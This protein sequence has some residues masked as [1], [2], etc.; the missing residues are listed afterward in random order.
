MA[1]GHENIEPFKFKKG[2][3]GNPNGRPRKFITTL[4]AH[5]YKASEVGDT[6]KVLLSL[7]LS[8]LKDLHKNQDDHTIM[9]ITCAKALMECYK[10]GSLESL[11]TML[12][13]AFGRPKQEMELDID[14]Q[15]PL[16]PD[17]E[18]AKPTKNAE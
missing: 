1:K 6:I 8:E 13:R 12:S 17:L 14:L 16:F 4:K 9:E 15:Q 10:K 7:K 18:Y 3:S 5:G 11:E 2:Q